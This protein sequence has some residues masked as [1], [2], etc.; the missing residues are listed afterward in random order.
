MLLVDCGQTPDW[1]KAANGLHQPVMAFAQTLRNAERPINVQKRGS[2]IDA[3]GL[4]SPM[5]GYP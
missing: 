3:Y 2:P 5:N 1:G 4:S